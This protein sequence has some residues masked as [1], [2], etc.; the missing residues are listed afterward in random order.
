M[1]LGLELWILKL[2]KQSSDFFVDDGGGSLT[3]RFQSLLAILRALPPAEIDI[4]Q[5]VLK[6]FQL[7]AK[8]EELVVGG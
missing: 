6:C 3:K 8:V 5:L 4:V 1:C 7:F 2:I